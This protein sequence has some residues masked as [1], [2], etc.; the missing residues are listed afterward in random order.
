MGFVID[1]KKVKD[2]HLFW[3]GFKILDLSLA[4]TFEMCSHSYKMDCEETKL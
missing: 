3:E 4:N 2:K 1:E